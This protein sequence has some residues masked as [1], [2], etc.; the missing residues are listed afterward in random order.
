MWPDHL[1]QEQSFEDILELATPLAARTPLNPLASHNHSSLM[2]PPT[3]D[4]PSSGPSSSSSWQ[5][6]RAGLLS[7][8]STAPLFSPSK[9]VLHTVLK[10][11]GNDENQ[12]PPE[13]LGGWLVDLVEWASQ[14]APSSR[15]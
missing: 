6:I 15:Q 10:G 9:D 11:E 2:L 3:T 14:P 5:T 7:P 13:G 4:A 1:F 12:Q 8:P